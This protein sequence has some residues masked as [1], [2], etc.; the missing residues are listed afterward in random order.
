MGKPDDR[1]ELLSARA[2]FAQERL[3]AQQEREPGVRHHEVCA[4]QIRGKLEV[5]LLQRSL[6][7]LEE[8]H[9]ALRTTFR[10]VDGQVHQVVWEPRWLSFEFHD[11]RHLGKAAEAEARRL[12]VE[13]SRRPLDL[14]R[15]PLYQLALIRL[16]ERE[17][18][19]GV[20]AHRAVSDGWSFGLL[21]AD[22]AA[23][24]GAL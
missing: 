21:T 17:H 24:Y 9:E 23:I 19:L 14:V 8:R 20:C 13:M 12:I 7:H 2:S 16:D 6:T 1:G 18:W 11:L 22:L 15:G 4:V 5:E 3:W 10:V